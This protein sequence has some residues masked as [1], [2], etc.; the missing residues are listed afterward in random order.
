MRLWPLLRGILVV[1]LWAVAIAALALSED[2]FV[3]GF[4]GALLTIGA[5]ALLNSPWALTAPLAVAAVLIVPLAV[6][7]D[8][9]FGLY[10][11]TYGTLIWA[12]LVFFVLPAT[13]ALAI[14]VIARRTLAPP[15]R[16]RSP[17]RAPPAP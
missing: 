17:R 15:A 10:D 7:D 12:T 4:G 1:V 9:G 13:V 2:P 5:G 16:P 11:D 3:Y 14:G 8:E 6:T